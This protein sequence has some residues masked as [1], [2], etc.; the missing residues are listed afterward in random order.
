I[1]QAA[2]ADAIGKANQESGGSVV[3]LA[4]SEYMVRSSGYLHSLD[5]FRHIVLRTND[6]GTPVLLGDVARI[7]V[8]PEMR[9]GIAELNGEGE[10]A[11]GA[12]VRR[13]GK[14]AV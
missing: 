4:E 5:D 14:E 8:G 13:A 11:G 7:Q 10:V 12:G 1:T 6:A 9:R 3:E 2:V